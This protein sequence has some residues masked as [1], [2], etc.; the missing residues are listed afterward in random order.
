MA[1]FLI[2]VAVAAACMGMLNSLNVFFIPAL[3]PAMF[4][5]ASIAVGVGL[6]PLAMQAGIQ[7]ILAMAIGTLV[8]GLGQ[9]LLQWPPLR[10][11]GLPLRRRASTSRIPD[12]GRCSR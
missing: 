9:V 11:A 3:S 1:P 7:P 6:V 4:N 10:R 12:C 8:G 2:L 5:V